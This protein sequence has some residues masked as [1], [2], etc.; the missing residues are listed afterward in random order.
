MVA[1]GPLN[2]SPAPA[3]RI[4]G[5]GVTDDSHR[6]GWGEMTCTS[7]IRIIAIITIQNLIQI[8]TIYIAGNFGEH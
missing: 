5:G 6:C 1:E 3:P 7:C 2:L 8:Y 4:E